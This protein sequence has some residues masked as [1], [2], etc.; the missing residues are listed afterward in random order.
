M[1]ARAI[2]SVCYGGFPGSNRHLRE[3]G[4]V[5]DLTRHLV[6]S[7]RDPGSVEVA[8]LREHLA[9]LAPRLVVFGS[10]HPTYEPLADAAGT[11]GAEVA[12]LWTS[13]AGQ[14]EIA[15]ESPL[16]AALA[17]DRRIG[18]FFVASADM[19]DVLAARG[20]PSTILP[21]ALVVGAP[22]DAGA[23][24]VASPPVLSLFCAPSEYRRKNVGACLD[25]LARVGASYELWVNGLAADAG[26]RA[27]IA[28]LKIPY[29]DLGWMDDAGYA[30]ALAGIDLGLQP[31]LADSFNYVVADHFARGIPVVV[32]RFVPCADGLPETV[33]RLLVVDDPADSV[34]IAAAIRRLLAAPDER[35]A[36]GRAV[37]AHIETVATRNA[38]VARRAL[39]AACGEP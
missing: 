1:T 18:R 22:P 24:G 16:L 31:S 8:F 20:R 13:S 29:R 11:A 9:T 10:W 6:I 32:S 12:V 30:R 23:R 35:R 25:A 17:R 7:S 21:H 5:T 34:A 38:A 2:V 26:Y 39:L 27:R 36:A 3:V 14:T 33:A 19:I 15:G 4:R 37:R 28:E